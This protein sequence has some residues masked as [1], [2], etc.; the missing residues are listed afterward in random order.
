MRRQLAVSHCLFFFFSKHF[1]SAVAMAKLVGRLVWITMIAYFV[2]V[3]FQL[4][5]TE[6]LEEEP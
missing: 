5:L 1:F 4:I 2:F 3:S 6:I